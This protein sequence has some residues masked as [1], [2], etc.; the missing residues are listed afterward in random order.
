MHMPAQERVIT[1]STKTIVHVIVTILILAF[2]WAIRDIVAVVFVALILA[3]V[4]NPFV[5]ALGKYKVPAALAAISFYVLLL[6]I[7]TLAFVL[8]MPQLANQISR[9]VPMFG[10]EAPQFVTA[11]Q[12]ALDFLRGFFIEHSA[13]IQAGMGSVQDQMPNLIRTVFGFLAGVFGGIM[14]LVLVFVLAFY[15]VVEEKEAMRWFKNLL[16][17]KHQR[18]AEN[19]MLQVQKKFGRWLIGQLCLSLI[20]GLL[21]YAGL[22]I[23]GVEGALLLGV[24]AAF[25]EFIPYVGPII[26]GIIVVIAAFAQS[27]VTALFALAFMILVQQLESN[28]ITPKVMQKAVG[29]NP[30]IS[31]IAFMVG[32]KLFGPVGMILAIPV[33]TAVSVAVMEYSRFKKAEA[34][35]A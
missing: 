32:A 19:L 24:V 9:M 1:I 17:E 4:M 20:I 2:L 28:L 15:M 34:E 11:L 8:I 29:V 5:D 3:A 18:F 22:M 30:V 27:P 21:Y 12:A 35:A 25:A 33:T 7:F 13:G 14:N 6:G 23:L 26:T 16:S 10:G 31:I